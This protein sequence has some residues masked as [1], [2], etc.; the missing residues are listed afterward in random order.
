MDSLTRRLRRA[1]PVIDD[2]YDRDVIRRQ[3]LCE[4]DPSPRLGHY[5]LVRRLGQGAMGVV[6]EARNVQRGELVALKALRA[7]DPHT[8]SLLKREFRALAGL[9]HENLCT[10]HELHIEGG[11]AYFTMDLVQGRD[12]LRHVWDAPPDVYTPERTFADFTRVRA[13]LRQLVAGL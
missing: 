8:L 13:V 1:R 4:T 6:Y 2:A 11:S 9:H 12:F 7:Q 10:L 3:V 5:E